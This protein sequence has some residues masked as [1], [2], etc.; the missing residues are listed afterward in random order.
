[1][2]AWD[3]HRADICLDPFFC[4]LCYSEEFYVTAHFF[5][6]F[7]VFGC[8]LGDSFDVYVVKNDSGIECYGSKD[9]HFTSCVESLDICGR[10]CLCVSKLC[11]KSQCILEFH[12]FLCHFGQDKVG[13]S[14]DNTHNFCHVIACQT[15]FERTDDR[16][17][18]CNCCFKEEVHM[19]CLCCIK[20][21]LTVNSDQVFV[22]GNYVFSCIQS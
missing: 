18:T 4:I 10:I 15:F 13:C 9:R 11:R 19:M 20:K 7:D 16:N 14:V 8:D 3:Q 12:S 2:I 17:S 1:M 5:G 6:V 21:L 22:R